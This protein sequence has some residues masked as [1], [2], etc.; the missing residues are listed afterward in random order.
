[1]QSVSPL[2]TVNVRLGGNGDRPKP[3]DDNYGDKARP[4]AARVRSHPAQPGRDGRVTAVLGHHRVAGGDVLRLH[5]HRLAGVHVGRRHDRPGHQ[6]VDGII[7][8]VNMNKTRR[9]ILEEA[10]DFL[11]LLPAPRLGVITIADRG[12]GDERYHYYAGRD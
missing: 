7:L 9:P 10:R 3:A 1:M 4:V 12:V 11:A 2:G 6:S 8:L 5:P